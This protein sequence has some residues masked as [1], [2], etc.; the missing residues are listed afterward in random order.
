MP[1]EFC[2][3]C[4]ELHSTEMAECAI[5]SETTRSGKKTGKTSKN[6]SRE[7][8]ALA[9]DMSTMSLVEREQQALPDIAQIELEDTL[10]LEEKCAHLLMVHATRRSRNKEGAAGSA[11][12]AGTSGC[13][14]VRKR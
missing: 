12:A 4:G 14:T 8:Q 10:A 3:N 5:L 11:D 9:E 7:D 1:K 13:C 6:P 2:A